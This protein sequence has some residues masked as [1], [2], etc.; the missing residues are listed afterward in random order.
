M[1]GHCGQ[2]SAQPAWHV[3]EA[4]NYVESPFSNRHI[5]RP[6]QL[7][8][9][10]AIDIAEAFARRTRALRAVEAEELGFGGGVA[11]AA[12]HTGVTAGENEIICRWLLLAFDF[13]GILC[14]RFCGRLKGHNDLAAARAQR[15]RNGFCQST[16]GAC[17]WDE[18][19]HHHIDRVL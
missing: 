12:L 17:R 19:I 15:E 14:V 18:P 3:A 10:D 1:A 5:R 4:A 13:D 6:N 11:D 16:A 9:I 2:Q 7:L 8:W